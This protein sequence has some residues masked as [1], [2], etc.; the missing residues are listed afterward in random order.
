MKKLMIG[1]AMM[2]AA[3]GVFGAGFGIYEASARGLEMGDAIVGDVSDATANYH[4]PA[5]LANA[6]NIQ[7]ALG[8]TLI[9]PFYDVEIEHRSQGKMNP[10]WFTVP[11]AY[12]TIPLPGDFALGLSEY[13]EYGAGTE[14]DYNWEGRDDSRST[15]IEQFTFNPNLA[16]KVTDWW[17]VSVGMRVSNFRFSQYQHATDLDGYGPIGDINSKVKGD[18]WGLGWNAAMSLKPTEKLK[19]GVVYRSSIKHKISGKNLL[20]GSVNHPLLGSVP[21]ENLGAYGIPFKT[22]GR[23]SGV[24]RT[25]SSVVFGANYDFTERFRG[26][27]AV[28]WTRWGNVKQIDFK[29]PNGTEPLKLRWHNS[30]RIGLG[31]EYDFTDWVCGRIGYMYDR[32]PGSSHYLTSVIP[33]GDRHIICFGPGFKLYDNL[34]LDLAY[35]FIRMNNEHGNLQDGPYM[36]WRNGGSHLVSATVRYEF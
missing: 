29:L 31:F 25:P 1:S 27:L 12:V 33:P 8:A 30:W 16:Y 11:H 21:V 4:N 15:T 17:N 14:Y 22:S 35:S 6:T 2:M 13:T 5:N 28:T 26:G 23:A 18:D 10:G 7:V 9:N 32:D 36:S 3:T 19:L 34:Y 24:V 20:S